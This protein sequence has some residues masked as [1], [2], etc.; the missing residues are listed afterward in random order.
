[1]PGYPSHSRLSPTLLYGDS[2]RCCPFIHWWG[3]GQLSLPGCHK[4]CFCGHGGAEEVQRSPRD[5][6]PPFGCIPRSEIPG[7]G[8]PSVFISLTNPCTVSHSSH[9]TIFQSRQWCT[10]LPKSHHI[11]PNTCDSLW[12]FLIVILVG[13]SC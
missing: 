8:G 5:P 2:T 13:L 4:R 6:A 3:F 10:S 9:C 7:S 11:F 12:V 1:M